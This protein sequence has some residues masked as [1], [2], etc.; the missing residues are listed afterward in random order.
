[1]LTSGNGRKNMFGRENRKIFKQISSSTRE[2]EM[3]TEK[4]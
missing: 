3:T 2:T 1:M 4:Y